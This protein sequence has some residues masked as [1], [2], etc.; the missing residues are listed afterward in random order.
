MAQDHAR[1]GFDLHVA[2]RVALV[3][4]EGA[5]LGLG[6]GDVGDVL[7]AERRDAGLDLVGREPVVVA[8]PP[9]EADGQL[10]HGGVAPGRDVG[11]DPLDGLPDLAVGLGKADGVGTALQP[12]FHGL[13]S[14]RR[15]R[16]YVFI[17]GGGR[18]SMPV[19]HGGLRAEPR[20][21]SR[22]GTVTCTGT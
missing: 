4:G 19:A 15:C 6:E 2:Q 10:A 3:L 14:V 7:L 5:D 12:V 8:V 22:P 21:T 13:P 1:Q 17:T 18:R 16:E 9:V 20:T 11:Q